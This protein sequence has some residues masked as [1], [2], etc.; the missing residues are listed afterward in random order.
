MNANEVV[1]G[2]DGRD[3][4]GLRCDRILGRSI[5]NGKSALRYAKDPFDDVS[6]L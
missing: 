3:K 2:S 5:E 6:S 1:E 4:H